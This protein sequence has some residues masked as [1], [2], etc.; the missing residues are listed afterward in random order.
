[1]RWELDNFCACVG[2]IQRALPLPFTMPSFSTS[3]AVLLGPQPQPL[4]FSHPNL[5]TPSLPGMEG[6]DCNIA[7]NE[8]VRGTAVCDPHA[9]CVDTDAGYACQCW[10]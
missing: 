4:P 3:E 7:V 10:W 8:C 5:C 1:M 2:Q 6:P 9:T